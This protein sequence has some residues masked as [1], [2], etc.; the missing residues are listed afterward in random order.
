VLFLDEPTVGLDVEGRRAFLADLKEWAEA[1]RTI[2][3]TT[4][5]LEEADQ[6]ARRVVVIDRGRIIA[7][8]TPAE[9]KARVAGKKVIMRFRG[10]PP[11]ALLEG[12]PASGLELHGDT[13]TMLSSRPVEVVRELM[14]ACGDDVLDLDIAGADLEEA[15][16]HL[17]SE[18]EMAGV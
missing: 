18:A 6:L 10:S 5:Y 14:R 8:A 3:L 15:F 13:A 2:I 9:I 16:V 11:R 1:G 7:D 17:T 12:L 4:H